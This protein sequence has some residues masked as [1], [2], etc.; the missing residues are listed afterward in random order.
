MPADDELLILLKNVL[1]DAVKA[2]LREPY[3]I[4]GAYACEWSAAGRIAIDMARTRQALEWEDC[5]L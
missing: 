5:W 4:G 1:F 2:Y 3:P